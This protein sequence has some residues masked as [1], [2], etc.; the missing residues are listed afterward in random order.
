MLAMLVYL[1][2]TAMH[3]VKDNQTLT[4]HTIQCRNAHR[5]KQTKTTQHPLAC[6]N[7]L[8]YSAVKLNSRKTT[9]CNRNSDQLHLP[10]V[11]CS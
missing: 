10:T 2:T 1:T 6:E 11:F 3:G 5:L 8:S 9:H 7:S 4:R